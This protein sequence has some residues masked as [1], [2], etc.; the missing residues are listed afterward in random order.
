MA[1][2]KRYGT[3]E[4]HFEG[5]FIGRKQALGCSAVAE[6]KGCCMDT[7]AICRGKDLTLLH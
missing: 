1:V 4:V 6:L 3:S 7:C 2:C 5:H